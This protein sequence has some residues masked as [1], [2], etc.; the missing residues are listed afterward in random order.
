MRRKI[1]CLCW[2]WG[3]AVG[4]VGFA[5]LPFGRYQSILDRN[6]FGL[7]DKLP[8]PVTRVETKVTER[9]TQPDFSDK[10]RLCMLTKT[11]NGVLVG[12]VHTEG[13][14]SK[15]YLLEIGGQKGGFLVKGADAEEGS[16]EIV[17][18]GRAAKFAI[19]APVSAAERSVSKAA[20]SRDP[21][22]GPSRKP[23]VSASRPS[24]GMSYHEQLKARREAEK[25]RREAA[26]RKRREEAERLTGEAL[27]KHLREYNMELIR[28][29]GAKGPPLPIALTPEEDRTLVQEGVL[30]DPNEQGPAAP[31][32]PGP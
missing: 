14:K 20:A 30:P 23:A 1:I 13:K 29:G 28:A 3:V 5:A 32:A 25:K 4:Q 8:K 10:V 7:V 27:R 18:N 6:P 21:R 19:G 11:G 15:S 12:F 22:P 17:Y 16:A 9:V 26:E 2:L 24:A 31:A